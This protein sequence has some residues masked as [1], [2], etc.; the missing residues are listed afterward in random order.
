[1]WSQDT[2]TADLKKE[3]KQQKEAAVLLIRTTHAAL[4]VCRPLRLDAFNKTPRKNQFS[5]TSRGHPSIP[6]TG[7]Q[8]ATHQR[9]AD[10]FFHTITISLSS[11]LLVFYFTDFCKHIKDT[12]DFSN[13][14]AS[15]VIKLSLLELSKSNLSTNINTTQLEANWTK[16]HHYK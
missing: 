16:T 3:S 14:S 11:T 8:P 7:L 9:A 10:C 13:N 4:S 5:P 12:V 2:F 1:M 6:C 15:L